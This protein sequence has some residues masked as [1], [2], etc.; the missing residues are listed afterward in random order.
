MN[1]IN[2]R[3]VLQEMKDMAWHNVYCCSANYAMT[4][5]KEG[6]RDDWEAALAKAKII[7]RMLAELPGHVQYDEVSKSQRYYRKYV[8]DIS[9]WGTDVTRTSDPHPYVSTVELSL[10]GYGISDA[11]TRIFHINHQ[12]G[13]DYFLSGKY[14]IDRH[15]R[16]DE[17]KYSTVEIT[18]DSLGYIQEIRW[19]DDE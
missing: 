2:R 3:S 4:E 6:M 13:I 14:D 15:E 8:G 5:P 19:A 17:G 9:S 18:V 10:E 11:D 7:D 12:L 16:Y 1:A